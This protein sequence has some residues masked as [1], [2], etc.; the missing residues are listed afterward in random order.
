MRTV[1]EW[2]ARPTRSRR[3]RCAGAVGH[4]DYFVSGTESL[5]NMVLI[6]IDRGDLVLGQDGGTA[7]SLGKARAVVPSGPA[8]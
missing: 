4:N 8:L 6:G 7:L 2:M 1:S 5:R 3:P